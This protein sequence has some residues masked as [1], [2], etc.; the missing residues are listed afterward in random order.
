[1]LQLVHNTLQLNQFSIKLFDRKN[2]LL[3]RKMRSQ[4]WTCHLFW[5]VALLSEHQISLTICQIKAKEEFFLDFSIICQD[6]TARGQ[7]V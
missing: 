4:G 3:L 1:M 5:L 7:N 6:V 2:W